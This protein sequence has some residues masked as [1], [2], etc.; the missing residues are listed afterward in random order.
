MCLKAS[1][2]DPNSRLN[3][4]S[5][6]NWPKGPDPNLLTNITQYIKND[7]LINV[8]DNVGSIF[9]GIKRL[10]DKAVWNMDQ[11]HSEFL[12]WAIKEFFLS[13]NVGPQPNTEVHY[14]PNKN[15]T[16]DFYCAYLPLNNK[17]FWASYLWTD[18]YIIVLHM[19]KL[20]DLDKKKKALPGGK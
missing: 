14:V 3:I 6:L 11:E 8:Y 7:Y 2:Y 4:I 20:Y 5:L 17:N 19:D 1:F 18:G 12:T 15:G 10:D 13:Q 16:K 9:I